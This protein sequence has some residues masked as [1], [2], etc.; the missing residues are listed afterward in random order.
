MRRVLLRAGLFLLFFVSCGQPADAM[1]T[2]GEQQAR[3]A[4]LVFRNECAGRA[5]CLTSW[6]RGEEFA[7]LGIGHFIWYPAGTPKAD[8]P[9][10]ESFPLL[11]GFLVRQGVVLPDWLAAAKACP[12]PD[13]A[14]FL[15]AQNSPR[16]S[17]LRRML[18]QTMPLQAAFL[19]HRLQQALPGILRVAP[20]GLRGHIGREYRRV[21][22]APMG[23]YVLTDYVNFKGEGV[24]QS[25][26]YDG[27]GWGL[28]QVLAGMHGKK[29]GLAAIEEFTRVADALLT[30]RVAHAPAARHEA[31]WLAGWRKRLAT[32]R[33]EAR[34]AMK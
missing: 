33:E 20:D 11:L 1:D 10:R 14:S 19:Q 5:S 9:F 32:Y 18:Q 3:I 4:Q 30:R 16:M 6:N 12:W 13:R 25:E 27:Q 17:A 28:M 23:E 21:A 8:K 31:R 26:R 29:P 24:L 22:D 15:A 34:R 7:S 2:A